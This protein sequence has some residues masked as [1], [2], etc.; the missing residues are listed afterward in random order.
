[1]KNTIVAVSVISIFGILVW[2]QLPSSVEVEPILY[3]DLTTVEYNYADQVE[4]VL[5][6]VVEEIV[7]LDNAELT[8]DML[9][10]SSDLTF[11]HAFKEARSLLGP[12]NTFFWSGFEY[13]TNYAEEELV[14]EEIE[15]DSSDVASDHI[16]E[17]AP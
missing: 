6:Q 11:S 5:E 1:M 13:T 3:S 10:G 14:I 7:E 2:S 17:Q 4:E 8:E 15:V 16:L 9:D 12:S